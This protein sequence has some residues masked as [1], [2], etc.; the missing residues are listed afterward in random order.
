MKIGF[1][2]YSETKFDITKAN[3]IIKHIKNNIN[4]NDEIV[5]GATMYGIPKLVYNSFKNNKKIG[6][7]CKQGYNCDL[8]PCDII[9]VI[10]DNWGD[11]SQFFIDYI[12]V[13]YKI[14]GGKQSIKEKQLAIEKKIPVYEYN[15]DSYIDKRL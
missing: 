1:I 6:I 5:S 8:Y 7:M 14:G 11:E 12:D 10:G 13:L 9:Y 4:E 3:N 2:G 15:L